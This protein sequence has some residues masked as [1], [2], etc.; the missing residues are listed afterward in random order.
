MWYLIV[1]TLALDFVWADYAHIHLV[2]A[3]LILM[4]FLIAILAAMAHAYRFRLPTISS[5]A[6]L[7][8]AT[9]LSLLSYGLLS[10]LVLTLKMPLQDENFIAVDRA[11]GFDWLASYNWIKAHPLLDCILWWAYI[12][13]GPQLIVGVLLLPL[14]GQSH[15][16]R[17]AIYATIISLT[18]IIAIEALLP[19]QGAWVYY[20]IPIHKDWIADLTALR[21]GDFHVLD[22]RHGTG[23]VVFPSF[24]CCLGVLCMYAC[25]FNRY[26]LTGSVVLNVTMILSTPSQ[27]SHY[28]VD[29]IAGCGVAVL[30][31]ALVRYALHSR[32]NTRTQAVLNARRRAWYW[33]RAAA[34]RRWRK[35]EAHAGSR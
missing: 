1:S 26:L 5:A 29:G 11:L 14:I 20:N 32:D 9:I 10:Y 7:T 3:P 22:I 27:G 15:I 16:L 12:L 28:L 30:S 21:A 31:I 4:A 24:H 8:Q 33:G 19:A 23:I 2:A 13:S 6:H 35:L 17:E 25:R 18:V 34:A